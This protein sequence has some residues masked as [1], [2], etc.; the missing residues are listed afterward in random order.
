MLNALSLCSFPLP[1]IWSRL[2]FLSDVQFLWRTLS[3]AIT[4]MCI[5]LELLIRDL[6]RFHVPMFSQYLST[7]TSPGG[8]WEEE[9]V[10][11][12]RWEEEEVV[13]GR[14]WEERSILTS[15]AAS[16]QC[17]PPKFNQYICAWQKCNHCQ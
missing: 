9:V 6:F 10:V 12:R 16:S 15:T 8:E 17:T 5:S 2:N 13:V 7:F 3:F 14:R 1:V 11:G 4:N